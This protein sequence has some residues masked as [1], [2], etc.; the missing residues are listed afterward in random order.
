MNNDI[1]EIS[2]I[3]I[4]EILYNQGLTENINQSKSINLDLQ[5]EQNKLNTDK[6]SKE[7][8]INNGLFLLCLLSTFI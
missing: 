8:D 4:G 2:F 3:K 7:N 1:P 6:K 5:Y